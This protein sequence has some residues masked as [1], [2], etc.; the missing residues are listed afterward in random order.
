MS[1]AVAVRIENIRLPT[2]PHG[3]VDPN[4]L[5]LEERVY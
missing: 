5:F 1:S 3:A 4:P 2:Y